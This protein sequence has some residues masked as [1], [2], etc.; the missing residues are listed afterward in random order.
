[1]VLNQHR[2]SNNTQGGDY[3]TIN[4]FRNLTPQARTPTETPLRLEDVT[5]FAQPFRA[6]EHKEFH[7]VALAA[8]G[9]LP[10]RNKKLFQIVLKRLERIDQVLLK[11]WPGL[12]RYAWVTVFKVVK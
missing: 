5:F 3:P 9:L 11:Q 8:F 1:V 7:L 4:L 2:R 10:F 6:L 12:G